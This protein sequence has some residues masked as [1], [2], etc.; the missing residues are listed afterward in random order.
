MASDQQK[1]ILQYL[2]YKPLVSL[3][4]LEKIYA[5]AYERQ[6]RGEEIRDLVRS[7]NDLLKPAQLGIKS[8]LCEDNNEEYFALINMIESEAAKHTSE[9]SPAEFELFKWVL[10]EIVSSESGSVSSI[11]CI[12][13]SSYIQKLTKTDAQKALDK[14]LAS[15]WLNEREGEV[16]LTVRA[17]L[18]LEPL[19]KKLDED[20]QN[21]KICNKLAVKKVACPDC[22]AK[23]HRYCISKLKL[24]CPACHRVWRSLEEEST[25]SQ[26]SLS[27]TL[28]Q[29]S[30]PSTSQVPN[31]R[32]GGIRRG[33]SHM[34]SDDSE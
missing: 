15:Q 10:K 23:F 19:L 5:A 22:G 17:L 25:P 20:L 28:S 33:R 14:F 1:Q 4:D 27:Q 32:N 29:T 11:D 12:N 24:K 26:M 13:Q 9:F 18:E 2:L 31:R 3:K 30:N 6:G 7:L 8:R 34:E 16:S 21:C